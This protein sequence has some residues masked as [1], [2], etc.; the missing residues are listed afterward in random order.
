V[1]GVAVVDEKQGNDKQ[2][3]KGEGGGYDTDKP[4][5]ISVEKQEGQTSRCER[6]RESEAKAHDAPPKA[7]Y[8]LSD[9]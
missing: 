4:R 6:K 2:D 7:P 5:P 9:E 8:S 3:A 1:G